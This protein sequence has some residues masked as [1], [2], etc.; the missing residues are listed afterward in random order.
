MLGVLLGSRQTVLGVNGQGFAFQVSDLH[1]VCDGVALPKTVLTVDLRALSDCCEQPVDGILGADCFA[2]V[3]SKS[4]SET[5]A[6][7]FWK[8]AI[9]T[10]QDARCSRSE[11]AR[12]RSAS[13]SPEIQHS[14]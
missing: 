10:L 11:C 7:A 6:S 12:M 9:Q 3:S 5:A 14:G 4:I 8:G 2:T 1:A 13:Q